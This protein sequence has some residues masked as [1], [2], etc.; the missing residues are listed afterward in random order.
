MGILPTDEVLA[1][2]VSKTQYWRRN[3]Q[4]MRYWELPNFIREA[5]KEKGYDKR[6]NS[7][8]EFE[9]AVQRVAHIRRSRSA[10]IAAKT[11]RRN[12]DKQRQTVFK[13]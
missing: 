2:E 3:F 5:L 12:S 9:C 11:R 4:F 10:Q 7:L 8:T 1:N 6:C 13:F